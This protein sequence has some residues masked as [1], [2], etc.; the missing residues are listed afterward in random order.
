M[1]HK[2]HLGKF[3]SQLR[4]VSVV[5]SQMQ[6]PKPSCADGG[7]GNFYILGHAKGNKNFERQVN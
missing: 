1:N 7:N 6:W 3:I 5:V 4:E 2:N